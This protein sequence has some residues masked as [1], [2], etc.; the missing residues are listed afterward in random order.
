MDLLMLVLLGVAFVAVGL[1][2]FACADLVDSSGPGAGEP[3]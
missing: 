3:P 2:V 1:Y